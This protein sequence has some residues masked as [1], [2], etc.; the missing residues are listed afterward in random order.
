LRAPFLRDACIAPRGVSTGRSIAGG[1][2]SNRTG[3]GDIPGIGCSRNFSGSAGARG[4]TSRERAFLD[5]RLGGRRRSGS[6][7]R[8]SPGSGPPVFA[9]DVEHS[10]HAWP[11][12]G[13]RG[14]GRSSGVTG[15]IKTG[16]E[17]SLRRW[18]T[19]V[20]NIF[21]REGRFSVHSRV[22]QNPPMA[23]Q[24]GDEGHWSRP[25]FEAR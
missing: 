13:C 25:G 6:S 11:R 24:D 19:T 18:R 8:P 12:R 14:R 2:P 20:S 17:R 7:R 21:E 10:E 22:D 23:A 3:R 15:G 16:D 5:H 9:E 4:F 1:L